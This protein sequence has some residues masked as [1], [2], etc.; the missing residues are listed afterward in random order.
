MFASFVDTKILSQCQQN[1][2]EHFAIKQFDRRIATL[3]LTTGSN[4]NNELILGHLSSS[5]NSILTQYSA[6]IF[7]T[8]E[9][10]YSDYEVPQ[11]HWPTKSLN[12]ADL[13]NPI[14]YN[15]TFPE[16]NS[17]IFE[18]ESNS[19]LNGKNL[20]LFNVLCSPWKH[21]GRAAQQKK[22]RILNVLEVFFNII[23][24]NNFLE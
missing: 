23:I 21:N 1:S 12:L 9:S 16:L 24:L 15:G 3:L 10:I 14:V 5:N 8:L 4:V 13:Q 17:E 7:E 22:Q 2:V 6:K 18:V 19:D 20:N 11:P